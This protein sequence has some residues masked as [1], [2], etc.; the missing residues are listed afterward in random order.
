MLIMLYFE[1]HYFCHDSLKGRNLILYNVPDQFIIYPEIV[2][3]QPIPSAG[4]LAPFYL[5]IFGAKVLRYLLDRFTYYFEASDKGPLER[6]IVKKELPTCQ[7]GSL[8]QVIRLKQ[9]MLTIAN[10]WFHSGRLFR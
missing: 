10:G 8:N 9:D 3:N 4:H 1:G 2:M 6:L 5:R 7:L